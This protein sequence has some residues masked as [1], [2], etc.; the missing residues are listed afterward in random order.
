M[1]RWGDCVCLVF[2][3]MEIRDICSGMGDLLNGK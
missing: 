3:G 1:G 2:V